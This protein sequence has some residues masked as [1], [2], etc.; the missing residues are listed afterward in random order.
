MLSVELKNTPLLKPVPKHAHGKELYMHSPVSERVSFVHRDVSRPAYYIH[1]ARQETRT[2]YC[3][4][5]II[6]FLYSIVTIIVCLP[7]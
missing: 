1:I 2:N 4:Q 5:N 7:N 3:F 6:N